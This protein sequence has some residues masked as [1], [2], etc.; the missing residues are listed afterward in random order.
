MEK[1]RILKRYLRDLVNGAER[2]LFGDT[3]L[4]FKIVSKAGVF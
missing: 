2:H 3:S 1:I 4:L